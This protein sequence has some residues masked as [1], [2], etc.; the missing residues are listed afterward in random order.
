MNGENAVKRLHFD[1][2]DS[3]QDYAKEKRADGVLPVVEKVVGV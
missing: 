3:T 1:C 2:L